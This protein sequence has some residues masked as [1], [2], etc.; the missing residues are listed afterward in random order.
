MIRVMNMG[1]GHRRALGVRT[2]YL[3]GQHCGPEYCHVAHHETNS[4]FAETKTR[5]ALKW[6]HW[7]AER[8]GYD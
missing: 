7:M 3:K 6:F 2:C 1:F 4:R 5:A 8:C